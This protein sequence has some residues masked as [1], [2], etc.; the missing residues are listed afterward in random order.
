MATTTI[1]KGLLIGINY[2]GTNLKLNGCI[3]DTEHLKQFLIDNKVLNETELIFMNDNKPEPLYPTKSNIL[4]Q[5]N[6]LLNVVNNNPSIP[7]YLFICYSGHGSYVS[8]KHGD[9]PD[10]RDET[11]C[12]IDHDKNGLIVDDYLKSEFIDKLGSNC[13][14]VLIVDACHSGTMF[15]LKYLYNCDR[16]NSFITFDK[17]VETKC[18][19]VMISGCMDSQTSNDAYIN[20]TYQGAMTASFISCYKH[21]ISYKQLIEN[22]RAWLKSNKYTQVP[23]LSSGKK[24]DTLG[25]FVTPL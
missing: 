10:G 19:V 16:R 21:G 24:I 3:N 12:P 23:Q 11:L 14:L 25:T 17:S 4:T 7:I 6:G 5:L 15:D 1:K 8:D 9:E 13:T 2:T 18:D 22:M 20:G